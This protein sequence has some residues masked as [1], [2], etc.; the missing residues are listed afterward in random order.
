MDIRLKGQRIK[1]I[2]MDDEQAPPPGTFGVIQGIDGIGQIHVKWDNGSTLAVQPE[3]D[4]YQI[5]DL[6]K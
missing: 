1:I 3:N 4:Q 5:F 6:T 2:K